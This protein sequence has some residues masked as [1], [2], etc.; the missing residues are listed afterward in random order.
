M[1]GVTTSRWVKFRAFSLVVSLFIALVPQRILAVGIPSVSFANATNYAA[2]TNLVALAVADFNGDGKPDLAGVNLD[3]IVSVLL[4]NGDGSFGTATNFDYSLDVFSANSLVAADVNSDQKQ[5]LAMV[6]AGPTNNVKILLGNGAGRFSALTN[7]TVGYSTVAIGADV[8]SDGKADL[9]LGR[10]LF[11]SSLTVLLG[12][13]NGTFNTGNSFALGGFPNSVA[14]GDFNG[15]GKLDLASANTS[16]NAVSILLG[17]GNGTFTN[18]VN[19]GF[20]PSPRSIVAG[21]L[22]S[23]GKLDLVVAEQKQGLISILLGTG[24]GS[25]TAATNVA[26]GYS[27]FCIG[28][29]DF[30]GDTKLDAAVVNNAY[31]VSSSYCVFM[32][33]DGEGHLISSRTNTVAANPYAANAVDLD[34]DG[35]IDLITASKLQPGQMSVLLNQTAP[36]LWITPVNANMVKLVWPNWSGYNLEFSTN[37]T[38]TNNWSAITNVPTI[39]NGSKSLSSS[40]SDQKRIYRLRR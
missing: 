12:N 2:S 11:D 20:T 36:P 35:R 9:V 29:G 34:A 4:G 33:G 5:D 31:P 8:N 39:I 38:A 13:G 7:Y 24:N 37:L 22:N 18:T 14:S 19:Y 15:D 16:S 21:D 17:N 3:G 23:D 26:A 28:L 27:P 32:L 30:N 1:Q 25:F 40:V 10:G 6:Q